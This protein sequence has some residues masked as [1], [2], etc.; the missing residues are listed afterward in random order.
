M[1]I[2]L[3]TLYILVIAT[4]GVSATLTLWERRFQTTR[5]TE[6]KIW[7]LAYLA[8]IAGTALLVLPLLT[9]PY[10]RGP[11][12][13]LMMTGYASLLLGVRRFEGRAVPSIRRLAL[14]ALPGA[15]LAVFVLP[16]VSYSAWHL[17]SSL[18]IAALC[19][20]TGV[21][22][23]RSEPLATLRSRPLAAAVFLLH[24]GFYGVRALVF[25]IA[26][27][28]AYPGFFSGFASVT[29]LEGVLFAVAAP[30]L[31]LALVREESEARILTTSETDYLTGLAN[32]RALF[33]RSRRRLA[34][35]RM[36][37]ESVAVLVFDLDHFK[38]INDTHGH[39]IGDEVLKL[40]ARIAERELRSEDF[41][42]RFG[43]EEFVAV[44][45][46]EP[47]ET[48]R[49]AAQTIARD[50]AREAASF[51][52]LAVVATVSVGLAL[53]QDGQDELALLLSRADAALYRAKTLGRNRIE[54]APALAA[55]A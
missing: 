26:Q 24:G 1:R 50:F 36:R 23:L 16:L 9:P 25:T 41:M 19:G 27:P 37:S 51:D 8:M 54:Q 20:W 38:R 47:T 55:A 49:E 14:L 43:G 48:V 11:G 29:M 18:L 52:G 3:T 22:L 4:L 2:D 32:R 30:M 34:E 46:G 13:A 12:S 5:R 39:D 33:T 15:A 44:V 6:L 10:Q 31:L 40:F 28:A 21:M 53:S 42:A 45:V 7:S 35:A 17:S